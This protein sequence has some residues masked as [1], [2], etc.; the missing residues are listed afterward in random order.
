MRRGKKKFLWR[1]A[2]REV[3]NWSLTEARDKA[4]DLIERPVFPMNRRFGRCILDA[5]DLLRRRAGVPAPNPDC[6]FCSG[7]GERFWHAPSCD[8]DYCALAG[9]VDDCDGRLEP[10]ATCTL[11]P[12][13]AAGLRKACDCGLL[14]SE[15]SVSPEALPAL[16]LAAGWVLFDGLVWLCPECGDHPMGLCVSAP[17][18]EDDV[19]PNEIP[20]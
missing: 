10:C 11:E 12:E 4:V 3:L 9:G 14:V 7:H 1:L 15:A 6:S 18:G 13:L 16:L 8:E 2:Q 20:F 17:W 19:D 5:I